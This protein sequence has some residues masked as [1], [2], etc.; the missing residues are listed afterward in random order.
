MVDRLIELFAE[1][2][3]DTQV[4]AIVV[5]GTGER[6]FSVGANLREI[7]AGMAKMGLEAYLGQRLQMI[8]AIESMA[9]PVVAAISGL[10]LGGGLE[11]AL[12]CHI[13]VASRDAELGLPEIDLGVIPAWGGTQ[14]LTRAVGRGRALEM[15]L[16]GRRVP[17]HEAHA[18]GLVHEVAEPGEA[19]EHATSLAAEL[20]DKAPLA[21]A[22]IL[23]CVVRGS[24]MSLQDGLAL[25]RR[26]V[27]QVGKSRD[28]IEGISAFLAK[29]K[30]E[31]RGE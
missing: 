17:A 9:K 13:R 22:A 29:R 12:G 4:R 20:A 14:R 3:S 1:L 31:F 24:E 27:M 21:I 26:L 28:A 23:E 6:A 19:L 2:K 5:T 30:P 11:L 10:C 7:G 25:E 16:R 18:M 15:M 8:D